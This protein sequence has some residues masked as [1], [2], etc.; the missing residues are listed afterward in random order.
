KQYNL[1]DPYN[2]KN[3]V[4]ASVLFEK[5]QIQEPYII[6]SDKISDKIIYTIDGR[7]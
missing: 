4:D 3:P 1:M 7:N 6:R 5:K 2:L